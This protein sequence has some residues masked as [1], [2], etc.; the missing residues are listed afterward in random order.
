M[1]SLS[2]RPPVF[3]VN[4]CM[5]WGGESDPLVVNSGDLLLQVE[6]L[7]YK[8]HGLESLFLCKVACNVVVACKS[9]QRSLSHMK[10]S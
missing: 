5:F 6:K 4:K 7:Y 9:R 1:C 2:V 8:L 10:E 3:G